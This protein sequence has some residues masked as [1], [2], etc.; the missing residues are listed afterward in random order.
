MGTGVAEYRD[1]QRAVG[2]R[3]PLLITEFGSDALDF[4]IGSGVVN[5]S[6]QSTGLLRQWKEIDSEP[7]SVCVG[8]VV[9]EL[10]D[11]WWK[12]AQTNA[13]LGV[14]P[15]T[16]PAVH[17]VCG[18]AVAGADDGF[19]SESW[20]G[21]FAQTGEYGCVV[22]R[23]AYYDLA[24]VWTGGE[25]EPRCIDQSCCAAREPTVYLLLGGLLV[26]LVVFGGLYAIWKY[27]ACRPL[28][29]P[30]PHPPSDVDPS[31]PKQSV[32]SCFRPTS[33]SN[34]KPTVQTESPRSRAIQT[35]DAELRETFHT[36]SLAHPFSL[37]THSMG[38]IAHVNLQSTNLKE[39]ILQQI[40][41]CEYGAAF[42]F[43]L[44]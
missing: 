31:H 22:P 44:N 39:L 42:S 27:G 16:D 4:R 38:F 5:E 10:T 36:R 3:K 23:R 34:G 2:T 41:R 24:K 30:P 37:T 17:S 35:I 33:G 29:S 1:F 32:P 20:F 18:H 21:L 43:D 15:E 40:L 11:E 28:P 13:P 7:V 6:M 14:C 9:F 25:I 26:C 19:Y 8:G 12:G